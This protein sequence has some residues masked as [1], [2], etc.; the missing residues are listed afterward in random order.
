M[1]QVTPSSAKPR[2]FSHTQLSAPRLPRSLQLAGHCPSTAFPGPQRHSGRGT[3]Q[4]RLK[5]APGWIGPTVRAAPSLHQRLQ[6]QLLRSS[7]RLSQGQARNN[8][9]PHL[10]E[11]RPGQTWLFW[12]SKDRETSPSLTQH[13]PPSALHSSGGRGR[14]EQGA[15]GSDPCGFCPFPLQQQRSTGS[16]TPPAPQWGPSSS[17]SLQ[18]KTL[19]YL[20]NAI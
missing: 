14:A 5:A 2:R 11:P 20:L 12:L 1:G 16:H 10:Q 13:H 9:K 7:P 18:V 15:Q 8:T 6:P 3:A 17:H 4:G 19:G